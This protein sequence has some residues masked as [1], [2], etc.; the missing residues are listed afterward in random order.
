MGANRGRMGRREF[1]RRAGVAGV[2]GI[3]ACAG[4]CGRTAHAAGKRPNFLFILVDDLG[5]S[6]L[7]VYGNT[8]HETPR[9][10]RF[11]TSS[12]MFENAYAA[13]PVCSPTRASIMT[14][15]Y[16]ARLGITD[17]I[18]GEKQ[19]KNRPVI[20]QSTKKF[21]PLKEV[22]IA[23]ALR[24]EGYR[25]AFL[26]KWHLGWWT[27][28]K[29]GWNRLPKL[30]QWEGVYYPDKQGF[31]VNVAGNYRGQPRSYFSPYNIENIKNG[32]KGEYLT[33]RLTNEALG[34]MKSYARG[35]KPFFMYLAYYTVHTPHQAKKDDIAHFQD[36]PATIWDHKKYAA[37]VR[38]LD[39]NVGRLLDG[40]V[41]NGLDDNTVVVFYS[42]NGAHPTSSCHPYR[43]HKG[44]IYDGG[45][46]EPLI[47]RWPGV[48]KP[49]TRCDVPVTSPDF[50]PTLLEIAGA[51]PRPRQ[52]VDGVS[53]VPLLRG[54]RSLEREAIYW[55]FPHF[56]RSAPEMPAGAV[57]AGDWKLIEYY[58]T[59]QV[60]LYNLREDIG[61]TDN[62]AASQPRLTR[63]LKTR[64]EKWRASVGAVMPKPNPTR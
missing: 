1:L 54:G 12:L 8:F 6:D 64:L 30:E 44:Q 14:G 10:D 5:V 9:L 28:K 50:Y 22:T 45:I 33:D 21:L 47:L 32:P 17:W 27:K 37:M 34:L 56:R 24:D 53:L 49:N 62:R 61:E 52:H 18:P 48:T 60:E 13:C 7:G 2:G 11:A 63:E 31:D 15:K 4:L 26:G 46:R 16:P 42:D 25:T 39:Y 59:G 35:D 58:T 23:E 19:P 51:P 43:G 36:K 57:R 20:C 41:K 29:E 38:C 55:H 3:A 40:L